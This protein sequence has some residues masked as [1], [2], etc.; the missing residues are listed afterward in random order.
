MHTSLRISNA[1]IEELR[2][3]ARANGA[4]AGKVSGAGGGG[5]MIFIVD[6]E[7]RLQL[8]DALNAAGGRAA[9][10]KFSDGGCET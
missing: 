4:L 3:I 1:H 2:D 5:F 8:V 10:V 9:P 7:D 6:P